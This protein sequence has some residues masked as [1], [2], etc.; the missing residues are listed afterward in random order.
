VI[1]EPSTN[2][3]MILSAAGLLGVVQYRRVKARRLS[4]EA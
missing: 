4:A 3:L 1:P 2:A